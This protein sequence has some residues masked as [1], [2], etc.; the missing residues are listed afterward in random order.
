ML[1]FSST[2]Y[3]LVSG[4]YMRLIQQSTGDSTF[5]WGLRVEIAKT[6]TKPSFAMAFYMEEENNP[7]VVLK[8]CFPNEDISLELTNEF[9]IHSPRY[10][11]QPLDH[12]SFLER[13]HHYEPPSLENPQHG[14]VMRKKSIFGCWRL[15]Q[16]RLIKMVDDG[17]ILRTGIDMDHMYSPVDTTYLDPDALI[18]LSTEDTYSFVLR[19][20][21]PIVFGRDI[22]ESTPQAVEFI[23]EREL[24]FP[25]ISFDHQSYYAQHVRFSFGNDVI[26][27][28]EIPYE[29]VLEKLEKEGYTSVE[30]G[31]NK[32][33]TKA[34]PDDMTEVK[35]LEITIPAITEQVSIHLMT[36]KEVKCLLSSTEYW[37]LG[38]KSLWMYDIIIDTMGGMRSYKITPHKHNNLG[39]ASNEESTA[40]TSTK[41]MRLNM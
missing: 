25:K 21:V 41:R 4:E 38:I 9:S 22:S 37:V 11:I 18:E 5:A 39:K 36:L 8:R 34:N 16:R 3:S 12:E 23:P 19:D 15:S 30:E 26:K 1:G 28:P 24:V 7:T 40:E 35:I 29:E 14:N 32:R 33:I 20:D 17:Q 6:S 13:D 2:Y 31:R 10:K 27:L